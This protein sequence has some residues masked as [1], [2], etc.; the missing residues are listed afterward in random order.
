MTSLERW[1]VYL[2]VQSTSSKLESRQK[3][4]TESRRKSFSNKK[5]KNNQRVRGFTSLENVT[6]YERLVVWFCVICLFR[7]WLV[8]VHQANAFALLLQSVSAAQSAAFGLLLHREDST[9]LDALRWRRAMT[10][11][12]VALC[13]KTTSQALGLLLRAFISPFPLLFKLVLSWVW[14][15]FCFGK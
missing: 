12:S 1:G 10:G 13:S 15:V 9:F 14:R 3:K 5:Q 2:S 6:G 8:I 11:I 7:V 4:I